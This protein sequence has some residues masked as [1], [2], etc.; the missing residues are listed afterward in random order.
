MGGADIATIDMAGLPI[1][2]LPWTLA[3]EAHALVGSDIGIMPLP[4]SPYEQGK[5]GFKLV[6]Y[7]S[8]ALPVVASPV[9]VNRSYVDEANG[10]LASDLVE[11]HDALVALLSNPAL[12]RTMGQAGYA[13]Y[14]RRFTRAQCAQAW[15]TLLEG[16]AP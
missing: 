14:Q 5:C 12:R 8:A 16:P 13:T 15:L 6:Q 10:F 1:E 4:D 2:R 9:G 7:W 11:W 3:G